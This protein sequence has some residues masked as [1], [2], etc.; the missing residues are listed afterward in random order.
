MIVVQLFHRASFSLKYRLEVKF[1]FN[2]VIKVLS[3][4]L[5]FFS[6]CDKTLKMILQNYGETKLNK[7]SGY[8]WPVLD[9]DISFNWAEWWRR[10]AGERR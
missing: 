3:S 10:A 9:Q 1:N 2:P 4:M 6:C 5:L 7:R 8:G